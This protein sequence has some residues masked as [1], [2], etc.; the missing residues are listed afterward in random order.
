MELELAIRFCVQ[1]SIII[2]GVLKDGSLVH[3][4]T[5]EFQTQISDSSE[6]KELVLQGQNPHLSQ[7]GGIARF[8]SMLS[9]LSSKY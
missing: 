4:L 3:S 7:G 5:D 8:V 6:R 2:D 1:N 9:A